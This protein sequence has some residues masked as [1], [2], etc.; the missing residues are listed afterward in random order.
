MSD[1]ICVAARETHVVL[2][3]NPQ[4]PFLSLFSISRPLTNVYSLQQKL[5]L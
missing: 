5:S 4:E 2:L 3:N 1:I